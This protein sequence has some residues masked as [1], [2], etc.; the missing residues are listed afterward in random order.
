MKASLNGRIDALEAAIPPPADTLAAELAAINEQ[1]KRASKEE[2][3]AWIQMQL[4]TV[5]PADG[6]IY[7]LLVDWLDFLALQGDPGTVPPYDRE[8]RRFMPSDKSRRWTELDQRW[9]WP[10]CWTG[11]GL[12]PQLTPG[13]WLYFWGQDETKP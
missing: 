5:T 3:I 13:H 2:K 4:A 1:L 11:A 6:D 10:G 12:P 7:T 9:S 8:N